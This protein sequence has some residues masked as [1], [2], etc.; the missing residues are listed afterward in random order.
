MINPFACWWQ[1]FLVTSVFMALQ[2]LVFIDSYIEV[3]FALFQDALLASQF[4][5]TS[6]VLFLK[7]SL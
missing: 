2:G 5:L 6:L 4:L 3:V 7:I 1:I